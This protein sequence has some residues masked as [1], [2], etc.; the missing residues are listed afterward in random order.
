ML[1]QLKRKIGVPILQVVAKW[2]RRRMKTPII[3]VT[4]T[5]GKTTTKELLNAVLSKKY[6][7]VCNQGNFNNH[8][9]VPLT[10]RRLKKDTE[11]AVVEMGANHPG[12][13]DFLCKIAQ[14]NYGLITNIGKAHLEGFGSFEGV[15]KTKNELY[16]YLKAH[17]GKAFVNKDNKLLMDLV[18]ELDHH[19][20]GT[21]GADCV[22]KP[23]PST[24]YLAV[25]WKDQ[26][27]QTKLVGDYNFENVAAAIAVGS[28]FGVDD[29]DIKEAIEGYV[30][31]NNRSQVIET[32]KNRIVMDAYNA[33]PVSMKAAITNFRKICGNKPLLILGDMLEL[34][35]A[36]E[37][38][39]QSVVKLI[40][41]LGFETAFLVGECMG[42]AAQ[43]SPY[44][45]FANVEELCSY[46]KENPVEGYDILIKG[47]HGVSLEKALEVLT[48]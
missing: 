48:E 34:G 28:Y 9:G 43:G 2:H 19:T 37:E 46:L 11:I 4:G 35:S 17:K 18:Q 45:T 7:T 10:L 20:Y 22:V 6:K 21:D 15:V 23:A 39:H 33:N 32:G 47:S 36:S 44:N 24:P 3:A 31:T 38:E 13:I 29:H 42:K 41:E 30:P 12:E 40:E 1:K 16:A 14:P 8:I 5:N 27:I 25:E 26:T